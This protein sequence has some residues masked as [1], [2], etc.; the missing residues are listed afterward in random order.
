MCATHEVKIVLVKEFL[1]DI[2]AEGEGYPALVVTPPVEFAGQKHAAAKRCMSLQ[3]TTGIYIVSI[4]KQISAQSSSSTT[5]TRTTP[6]TTTA[7][8]QGRLT[9]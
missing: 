6:Y 1:D 5:A 4:L 8:L 3:I 2:C 9:L 7:T